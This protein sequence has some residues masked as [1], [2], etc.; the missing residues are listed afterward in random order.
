ML[1]VARLTQVKGHAVLSR[2]SPTWPGEGVDVRLTIVGDG[3]KRADL[4]RLAAEL[5]VA[6]RI[7]FAGA[8]GQDPIREHYRRAAV[9]CLP[10]FAEGVPVVLMEAMAM[11]LPWWRAM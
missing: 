11:A 9:F 8:V 6:D 1:T 4:E 7:V 5:G 10:S 3:P 2:R